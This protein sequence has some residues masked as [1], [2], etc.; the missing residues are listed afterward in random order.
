MTI[1]FG[2]IIYTPRRPE[3]RD[4]PEDWREG[5]VGTC[6][7][8]DGWVFVENGLDNPGPTKGV[9]VR[10][11]GVRRL[12]SCTYLRLR[13]WGEHHWWEASCFKKIDSP[14]SEEELQRT[15]RLKDG[16]PGAP[17]HYNPRELTDA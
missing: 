12:E 13:G 17:F 2:R 7:T 1:G 11:T 8:G 9:V 10:V 5:D 15:K 6:I 14:S 4:T 16:P 3:P